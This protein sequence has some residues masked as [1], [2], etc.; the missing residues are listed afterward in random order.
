M[1]LRPVAT[2]AAG[3]CLGG[4]SEDPLGAAGPGA[5][6][7]EGE[8]HLGPGRVVTDEVPTMPLR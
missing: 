5:K 2:A 4:A 3:G 1:A 8:E 6:G 7:D